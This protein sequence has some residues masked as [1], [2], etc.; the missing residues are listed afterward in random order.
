MKR[1]DGSELWRQE[2][3]HKNIQFS[4]G[5]SE[6]GS[7]EVGFCSTDSE[8]EFLTLGSTPGCGQVWGEADNWDQELPPH[9]LSLEIVDELAS[10]WL[11]GEDKPRKRQHWRTVLERPVVGTW[12]QNV[13]ECC[14]KALSEEGLMVHACC[15]AFSMTP[16][17]WWGT[18]SH[19]AKGAGDKGLCH[20][21]PTCLLQVDTQNLCLL[22]LAS[23]VPFLH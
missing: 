3:S 16:R 8:R 21:S 17:Q 9:L 5:R 11:G 1:S 18:L 22:F 19:V 12:G 15:H 13:Q 14:R 7:S 20:F 10:K 23:K 6:V 2:Y 4:Q